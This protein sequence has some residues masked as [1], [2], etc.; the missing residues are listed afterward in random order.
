MDKTELAGSVL[1]MYA[2]D[3][4][5]IDEE[6]QRT[7][8]VVC[9]DEAMVE[10]AA[11]LFSRLS[12]EEEIVGLARDIAKYGDTFE[13]TVYTA[14][15]GEDAGLLR[16]VPIDPKEMMRH[17]TKDGK[18]HGYRQH[19]KKFRGG[20][21]V[22]SYPWDFIH[23]RMRGRNRRYPYG[24]S[25]LQ[26]AIRPWRQ[27]MILE[28]WLLNYQISKHPDRNLFILDSG[29]QSDQETFD[30]ARRFKNK[31]KRHMVIDPM[32][33]SGAGNMTY[34]FNQITPIEDIVMAIRAGSNTRVEKL[35]G[36][37]NAADIGPITLTIMKFFAAVRAPRN[38]FGIDGDAGASPV[39]MK[40]SLCN[41]D[42]RYAR[43]C[44]RIQ[45]ALKMGLTYALMFNYQLKG[46]KNVE[47]NKYDW[48]EKGKQFQVTMAKIGF[49]AE[50]ERLSVMQIRQ[51]VAAG[52]T[53]MARD[54]AA[55][56]A[57]EWTAYILANYL[58]IPDDTID[59]VLRTSEEMQ[60]AQN[61]TAEIGGPPGVM[62]ASIE[63]D[64]DVQ[65]VIEDAVMESRS[66][67]IKHDGSISKGDKQKLS[68]AIRGNKKLRHAI[69]VAS[70][71]WR[72]Y[73]TGDTTLSGI[74]ANRAMMQEG[75]TAPSELT[76]EDYQELV[77]EDIHQTV[78]SGA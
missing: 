29:T 10:E 67:G 49:L 11:D 61:A 56:K 26:N 38:Y 76:E 73:D 43:T 36:S 32:N 3:A 74:L 14:G 66:N 4:T 16:L 52:L 25:I 18:L 63:K 72:S 58:Q 2:E 71:L 51:Q 78:R 41:Q 13:R 37:G 28:D 34:R 47:K 20:R 5:P 42:V 24:T 75:I 6:I 22:D 1:D 19:G 48:T 33:N 70:H 21:D 23:F 40:A 50:L 30:N 68:D 9:K 54:N 15:E 59:A 31:L 65:R 27:F 12:L 64:P 77:A 62:F 60:A 55:Y 45:R 35:A 7:A 57:A 44:V 17:E 39:D 53:D 46:G 69:Q 8:W